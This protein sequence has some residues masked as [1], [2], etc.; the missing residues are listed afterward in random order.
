VDD[1]ENIHD[2]DRCIALQGPGT[3][4]ARFGQWIRKF[5][6][7]TWMRAQVSPRRSFLRV[8]D[9]VSTQKVIH[10]AAPLPR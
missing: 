5:N 1:C 6:R 3:S 10:D 9:H 4:T 7:R 8:L 2:A